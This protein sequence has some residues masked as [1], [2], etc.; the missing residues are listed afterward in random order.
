MGASQGS[1]ALPVGLCV[2]AGLTPNLLSS[3]NVTSRDSEVKTDLRQPEDVGEKVDDLVPVSPL[4]P[5]HVAAE[6]LPVEVLVDAVALS[7]KSV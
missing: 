5:E 6:V 2:N 7:L 4:V 3:R 1:E